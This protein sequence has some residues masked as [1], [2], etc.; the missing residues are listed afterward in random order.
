MPSTDEHENGLGGSQ[1]AARELHIQVEGR[2]GGYSHL[3]TLGD[4]E[5]PGIVACHQ[6][7]VL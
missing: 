1:E 4:T 3:V 6:N 7:L 2:L 5:I